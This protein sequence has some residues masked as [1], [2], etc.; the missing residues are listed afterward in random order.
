M[1]GRKKG[2]ESTGKNYFH[3]QLEEGSLCAGLSGVGGLKGMALR[4]RLLFPPSFIYLF[5][6][7]CQ[8]GDAAGGQDAQSKG[9]SPRPG[10]DG[11]KTCRC[12]SKMGLLWFNPFCA[13]RVKLLSC[14]YTAGRGN[15]AGA[16]WGQ[17]AGG[18]P[19]CVLGV[20]MGSRTCWRPP[21]TDLQQHWEGAK[22]RVFS[23][24]QNS[25]F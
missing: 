11:H 20:S 15:E 5:S 17:R 10:R 25:S 16:E 7:I 22:W 21:L 14:C 12:Y 6:S 3:T 8:K 4:P 19:P 18:D 13:S 9:L 23:E 24:L 1:K 2:S